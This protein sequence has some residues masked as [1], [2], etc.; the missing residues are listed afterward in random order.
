MAAILTTPPQV[1]PPVRAATE[2][3]RALVERLRRPSCYPHPVDRVEVIETHISFVLLAGE[4]A[5]KIKKPVRLPFL[6]FSSLEARRF[7]CEEELRLNGRT[8]PQLY[9]EVVAIG[10][11]PLAI[12]AC[13]A[14]VEYAV[15]MRR[16]P[17]EALLDH[18]AWHGALEPAHVEALARSVARFHGAAARAESCAERDSV[19]RATGSALDNFSE[20][21]ALEATPA[22]HTALAELRAW[23]ATQ[24]LALAARFALRHHDGF[25]RECHGDLHLG[26]V[27]LL[28]G[29]PAPFD[30]I[31]FNPRL[32]WIDV[33]SDVAFMVMDLTRH[34][35]PRLATRFLNAYLEASG[36]YSGLRVLRFYLVY[37]AI[38]RAKI[39]RLRMHQ[40]GIAAA[41][42]AAAHGDF[43]EYLGLARRLARPG[44]P[45]LVLMHGL[46]G[47]GKTTASQRLAEALHAVRVRS[48]VERKRLHGLAPSAHSGSAPGEGLYTGSISQRTYAHLAVL[49]HEVLAA[50]FPV[51]IDAASLRH[52]DRERFRKAAQ[53]AGAAFEIATC[54]APDEVLANRIRARERAASDASEA[55][56]DV[57]A[58]QRATAEPLT[59][60]ERRHC[61]VLDTAASAEWER[62]ADSIARRFHPAEG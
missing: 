2:R 54:I 61:V 45:V 13:E 36:D 6:D 52:E 5:Y 51:V 15:R 20:V 14:P 27:A 39:A 16:F 37:R 33:M 43:A 1:A 22:I 30:C 60:D 44:A 24:R 47:S 40:P 10:G 57:L 56:L 38:V 58:L 55:G 4:Y 35:L 32:R 11:E 34:G 29:D 31:E 3:T 50:G 59:D 12:G 46:A 21:D 48:D 7:C 42:Y 9:L 28:D 41:D 62:A 23:T 53:A 25:V 49:A 8:A 26:N 18:L 19:E 17:Q